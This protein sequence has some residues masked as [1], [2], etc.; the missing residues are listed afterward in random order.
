MTGTAGGSNPQVRSQIRVSPLVANVAREHSQGGDT[1]SNPVGTTSVRRSR[2][3][4]CSEVT[5]DTAGE[6]LLH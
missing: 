5:T 2:A 4:L 1:G 6:P 3:A